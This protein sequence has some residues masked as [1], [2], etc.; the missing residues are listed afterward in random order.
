MFGGMD[1]KGKPSNKLY[2]ITPNIE[3]NYEDV[4]NDKCSYLHED[5][6]HIY[7]SVELVIP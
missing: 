3:L 7:I 4:L 1:E 6:H 2:K 5:D